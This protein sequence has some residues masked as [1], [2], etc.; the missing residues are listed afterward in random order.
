MADAR[1]LSCGSIISNAAVRI[2]YLQ[3]GDLDS[4][5]SHGRSVGVPIRI[6]KSSQLDSGA[7]TVPS[8]RK[9]DTID[10]KP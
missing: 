9:R 6:V 2:M 10:L 7:C 4:E 1:E 5:A 3:C 8:A